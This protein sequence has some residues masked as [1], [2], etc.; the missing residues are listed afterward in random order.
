MSAGLDS[1][2][3]RAHW[4]ARYAD[5]ETAWPASPWVVR[6]CLALPAGCTIV[7]IAGGSGRHAVPLARAGR[8]VIVVDFIP[9]AVRTATQRDSGI[10][11]AVADVRA[12]PMRDGSLGAIVCVNFLDRT[13]F[14]SLV[15]LLLPGGALIYETFTRR[16]LDLVR[17]GRAH[18]P[19]NPTY[20]LD[21]GELRMLVAPLVVQEYTE[22]LVADEVGERHVA[23]VV[24]VKAH[25]R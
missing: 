15:G 21:D 2:D 8:T 9:T 7:D 6:Q 20:L 17:A 22:G 25:G 4:E 3:D 23:R 12:L 19:R 5:A 1:R 14:P 11:G 16:H 18:G 10:L 24:A 13:L